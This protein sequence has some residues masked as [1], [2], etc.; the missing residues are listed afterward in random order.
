MLAIWLDPSDPAK[1]AAI[2]Y[3][4]VTVYLVYAMVLGLATWT[5]P[6]LL[7]RLRAATHAFDV[8]IFSFF[9]YFS[10]G[11][12]SPFFAYFVFSLVCGT[13]R[14]QWRGTLWTAVGALVVFIG[15]G[16]Y[17][18][19]VLRDPEFELNRFV[20]RIATLSVVAALLGYLS[21]YEQKLLSE[22]SGLAR[23][24]AEISRDLD[25]LL[26]E[27]LGYSGEVLGAPRVL[28]AWEEPE[29]P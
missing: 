6:D 7:V 2:V 10:Q 27:L 11:P 22:I 17:T 20:I 23:W 16:I 18:A 24:P 15:M 1:Y 13:L 21:N 3:A 28:M 12:T 9:Q 29:E 19:E 8:A 14:W 4:L 25:T 5:F 26:R